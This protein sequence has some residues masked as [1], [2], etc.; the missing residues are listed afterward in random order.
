LDLPEA[1][2]SVSPEMAA[3]WEKKEAD[4]FSIAL[5]NVKQRTGVDVSE[6]RTASGATLVTLQGE[7]ATASSHVLLLNDHK[8]TVGKFGA[9][10][11]VPTRNVVICHPIEDGTVAQAAEEMAPLI[12]RARQA[13]PGATSGQLYWYHDGKFEA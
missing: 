10:V 1:L 3:G 9:I 11:A 13:G 5:D 7:D 4:L 12:Q 2:Q 6:S 8:Q